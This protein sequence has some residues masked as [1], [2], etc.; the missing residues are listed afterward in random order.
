MA[1]AL[2]GYVLPNTCSQ[3]SKQQIRSGPAL[4]AAFTRP[5]SRTRGVQRTITRAANEKEADLS[6][7]WP[8]NWSLASY[9]DVGEFFKNSL[10][11]E[12]A[13]NLL[14]D[15][16]ATS[17]KSVTPDTTLD[18]LG[19]LFDSISGVPVTKSQSDKTLGGSTV[20]DVMSTPPIAA[21]PENKVADAAVMMLKHKVH[22]IPVVDTKAQ[23]VG[24]VTRTDIFTALAS[25]TGAA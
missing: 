9:E 17:V 4:S 25:E 10:F 13:G 15:V 6:G 24:I 18:S 1:N 23:L 11:K 16:M 22:R 19:N 5:S 8:V 21:R 14:K 20:G 3:S 12:D 2:A 7:E